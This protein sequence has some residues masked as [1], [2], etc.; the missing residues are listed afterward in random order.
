MA[1]ARLSLVFLCFVAI[2]CSSKVSPYTGS[3]LGDLVVPERLLDMYAARPEMLGKSR[4]EIAHAIQ[5]NDWPL[6]LKQDGTYVSG[7]DRG[8]WKFND[9]T[10]MIHISM[11]ASYKQGAID[12]FGK[13]NGVPQELR[14]KYMKDVNEIRLRIESNGDLWFESNDHLTDSGIDVD[15]LGVDKDLINLKF[16]FRKQTQS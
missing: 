4:E 2:A 1:H 5:P 11:P 12:S 6:E 7:P 16:L 10:A 13:G 14:D 9:K 15:S 8:T 3:Y